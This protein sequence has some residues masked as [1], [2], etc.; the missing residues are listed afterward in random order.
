VTQETIREHEVRTLPLGEY[1]TDP[2]RHDFALLAAPPKP[3]VDTE[4]AK[5]N[6]GNGA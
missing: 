3:D 6:V 2:E 1:A 5:E 4:G